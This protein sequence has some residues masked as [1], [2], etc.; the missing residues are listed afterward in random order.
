MT[1]PHYNQ[2]NITLSL[3]LQAF[4]FEALLLDEDVR[5][6]FRE[7]YAVLKYAGERAFAGS[8]NNVG[9]NATTQQAKGWLKVHG[10]CLSV[11]RACG[12]WQYR[13]QV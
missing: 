9:R 8:W 10:K 12:P 7:S 2:E 1:H 5:W 13:P 4:L 11:W 6:N 3:S